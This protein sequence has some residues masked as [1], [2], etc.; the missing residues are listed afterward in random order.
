[1]SAAG[2]FSCG[3][4]EYYYLPQLSE[5]SITRISN[6]EAVINLPSI[7]QYYYA[8]NYIIFYRIYIS[9]H[10]AS[11]DIQTPSLRYDISSYL[12]SDYDSLYSLTDPTNS[13]SITSVNTFINRNYY[14]LEF[15]GTNTGNILSGS[16][17]T[18]RIIFPTGQDRPYVNNNQSYL[19]R[20]SELISPEPAGDP[21]FRNTPELNN[22]AYAIST[23]N[24]DVAPGRNNYAYVSMYIVAAGYNNE[25]FSPIYSKPTH[26]SIFKLP[27]A[28]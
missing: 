17:G 22:S 16:G 14:I 2:L 1:M 12:A 27:D 19:R 21:F 10:L 28:N 5:S 24:A 15:D 11:S 13:A 4:D 23:K 8:T 7:S 20:S 9:D 6:T 25:L 18:L 26:I 3:I